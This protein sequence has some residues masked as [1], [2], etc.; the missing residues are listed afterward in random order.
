MTQDQE[1]HLLE[2]FSRGEISRS[3]IERRSGE[4]LSFGALLGKLR[5]HHLS[6]PTTPSDPRSRGVELIRSLAARAT[7]G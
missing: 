4:E 7:H 1:K 2:A 6:L 5:A 3:E